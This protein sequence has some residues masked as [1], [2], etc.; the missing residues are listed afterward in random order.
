MSELIRPVGLRNCLTVVPKQFFASLNV[1][2]GRLLFCVNSFNG[3]WCLIVIEQPVILLFSASD[4]KTFS[5]KE[6][7]SLVPH[8]IGA[9]IAAILGQVVVSAVWND[10]IFLFLMA[11]SVGLLL[12]NVKVQ[13]HNFIAFSG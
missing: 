7:T 11:F 4:G 12:Q 9:L 13:M 8:T 3:S 2:P 5:N 10:H 6:L 1:M